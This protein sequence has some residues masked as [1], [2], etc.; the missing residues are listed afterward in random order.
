MI[1]GFDDA[2]AYKGTTQQGGELPGARIRKSISE[3][4]SSVITV[5]HRHQG[6]GRL[7]GGQRVRNGAGGQK[8][9]E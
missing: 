2:L 7:G 4:R 9:L 6:A 3:E 1:W 8:A 5:D